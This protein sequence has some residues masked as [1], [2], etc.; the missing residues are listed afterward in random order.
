MKSS[1]FAGYVVVLAAGLL[2][3]ALASSARRNA[4]HTGNVTL[5]SIE[6]Q[7]PTFA[8]KYIYKTYRKGKGGFENYLEITNA[9]KGKLHISF[10]GTYFY[11]AGKDETFHEGSGEG[12]GQVKGNVVTANLTDGVGNCRLTLTFNETLMANEYTVTV[13]STRCELNVV[14]DGLYRKQANKK[15]SS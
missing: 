3:S 13:K 15:R 8:G 12:D 11:M 9:A 1:R 6:M 4:L 5:P 14:P 7:A 2:G 10:E